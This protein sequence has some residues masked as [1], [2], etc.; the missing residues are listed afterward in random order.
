L[1]LYQK[2]GFEQIGLR[3]GYYPV[4]PETGIRE[5]AIVMAKSIKLE[6]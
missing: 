6:P 1:A 4:S 2:L 3:K 5:D